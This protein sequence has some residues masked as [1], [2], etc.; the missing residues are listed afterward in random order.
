RWSYTPP[1]GCTFIYFIFSQRILFLEAKLNSIEQ[2]AK[3]INVEVNNLK[4]KIGYMEST[5]HGAPRDSNVA[6]QEKYIDLIYQEQ[7]G[8]APYCSFR[9]QGERLVNGGRLFDIDGG[10]QVLLL[11]RRLS[12]VG[13]T[14]V[15]SQ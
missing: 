1:S 14:S 8:H 15:L 10:R 7:N 4:K 2:K 13:G 5:T 12:G 11:A 6:S 9:H 3:H